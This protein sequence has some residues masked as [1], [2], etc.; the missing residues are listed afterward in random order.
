M[1][2]TDI[3][4]KSDTNKGFLP[5]I[6]AFMVFLACITF[7]TALTGKYLANDWDKKISKNITIQ[8]LPDMKNKN[9]NKEIEERIKNIT[10]ILKQTPGIKSSYAMSMNETIKLLKPWLGEIGED[11]LDI[12]LPRIISVEVSE[13]IPLNI[14]ALTDEIKNYSNLITIENYESWMNDFTN[15]ISA[16]Q[17]L[18]GLIV[19]LILATT[20]ITIAH[21]TKSGLIVNKNV[22]EIMHM[23][24]AHNSYISKQ[25][26]TQMMK[27]SI[28]GG[29]IGY[30]ISCLTIYTIQQFAIEING[31]IISNITFSNKTHIYILAI[32]I[33]AGIISKITAVF[34][35]NKT[36]NQ[37]V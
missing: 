3:A 19:I 36:L 20:G 27:L 33:I 37:M 34:T 8:V 35:I 13:I 23:V 12:P 14:R 6:T 10:E 16:I 4:F 30:I 15:T 18:L 24:G 29:I 5:F 25:F 31:G 9:T 26:S 21:T 22:I 28:S 2:K 17:T 11:K 7:A 32:P 1:F